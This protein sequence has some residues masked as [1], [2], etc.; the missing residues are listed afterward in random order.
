VVDLRHGDLQHLVRVVERL[1][2]RPVDPE[3]LEPASRAWVLDSPP[4]ALVDYLEAKEQLVAFSRR[5]LADGPANGILITPTLTRLPAPVTTL[6]S[7][8]GVT[9]DA[10]RFS[11][12]ACG[13]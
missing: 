13:T 2:G 11:A 12:C 3:L 9:D 7:R 5:V 6:R 10:V 1:H 8:V 4:I